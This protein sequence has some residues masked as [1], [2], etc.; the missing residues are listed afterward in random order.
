LK[1][2]EIIRERIN[3]LGEVESFVG[4]YVSKEWAMSNVMRFTEDEQKQMRKEIDGEISSGEVDDPD[5]ELE[6]GGQQQQEPEED[7][8]DA[9]IEKLKTEIE[10]IK[11]GTETE[12]KDDSEQEKKDSEKES[13]EKRK[14][15]KKEVDKNLQQKEGFIPTGEDELIE[16]MNTYMNR[17]LDR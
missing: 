3:L 4:E 8:R 12:K 6:K 1:E 9:E 17:L 11:S 7:P 14:K 13:E 16:N 5:E 2:S 10:K 15:R